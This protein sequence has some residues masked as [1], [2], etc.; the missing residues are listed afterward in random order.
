[1]ILQEMI[2]TN[3]EGKTET[4]DGTSLLGRMIQSEDMYSFYAIKRVNEPALTPAT[5][6]MAAKVK[7][8]MPLGGELNGM[9]RFPRVGEKVVVAIE[10]TSHYLMGYLPTAE[11]P[12]ADKDDKDKEKTEVF[13]KEAQVLRY[14]KTGDN[15][16]DTP[17]S[18]IGFYSETTEWKEAAG[19]SN[20]KIDDKSELPIIDKIKLTSTGDIESK[21]Q[22]LNEISAQRISLQSKF[23]SSD[24]IKDNSL[25]E[26]NTDYAEIGK[27]DVC[28]SADRRIILDAREGVLLKCGP[29]T[30]ALSPSGLDLSSGKLGEKDEGFGPFDAGLS[31][32]S[33]G[34]V[35][36]QGRNFM[37]T[38]DRGV[39]W[40]DG[41]GACWSMMMGRTSFS[42]SAVNIEA[43]TTLSA[44]FNA[45]V[46]VVNLINQ[47]A[48]VFTA[49]KGMS[50]VANQTYYM[51]FFADKIGSF[52]TETAGEI[53]PKKTVD[54]VTIAMDIVYNVFD[55]VRTVFERKRLAEYAVHYDTSSKKYY[56][57]DKRFDTWAGC[58]IVDVTLQTT[59][60]AILLGESVDSV[61]HKAGISLTPHA[62][63]KLD[64]KT[65]EQANI[66][67]QSLQEAAAGVGEDAADGLGKKVL[68]AVK[69]YGPDMLQTASKVAMF[70]VKEFATYKLDSA[71]QQALKEL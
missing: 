46:G 61:I 9:Y 68:N 27:G 59:L 3:A 64:S 29:A 28:I 42:G 40:F 22:N 56:N 47:I 1:M 69:K 2:V 62:G 49:K 15:K 48:S 43:S 6:Q 31:L 65:Y 23:L 11:M 38:F 17:Y 41:F 45:S 60:L 16:A 19:S 37:A 35:T 7:I 53:T 33:N 36:M 54:Y 66:S 4:S 13:N 24:N 5:D 34:S 18:E 52:F 63:I 25:N 44:I 14:K 32:S 55:S 50:E 21:A 30:V 51:S 67:N 39:N 8:M 57:D 70:E 26:R 10:G 12:F 58:T 71:T 20:S